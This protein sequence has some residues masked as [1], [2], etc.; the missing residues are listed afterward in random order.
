LGPLKE[1]ETAE[2]IAALL[3]RDPTDIADFRNGRLPKNV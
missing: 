2:F 3:L 1:V